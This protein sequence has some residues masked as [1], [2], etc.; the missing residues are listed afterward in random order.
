MIEGR[1]GHSSHLISSHLISFYPI[2][3]HPIPSQVMKGR[4]A[5]SDA[6]GSEDRTSLL[7]ERRQAEEEERENALAKI[8][9]S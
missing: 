6:M 4:T 2:P 3:S 9:D 5:E 7:A 1:T 8:K